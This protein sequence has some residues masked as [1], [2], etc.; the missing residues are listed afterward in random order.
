MPKQSSACKNRLHGANIHPN[1]NRHTNKQTQGRRKK[2]HTQRNLRKYSVL[3]FHLLNSQPEEI[4]CNQKLSKLTL[5]IGNL[6]QNQKTKDYFRILQHYKLTF[7][8][9]NKQSKTKIGYK[10]N[11]QRVLDPASDLPRLQ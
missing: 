5:E 8:K 10:P 2:P 1:Q 3:Q 11:K 7:H 4:T 6:Y 9:A